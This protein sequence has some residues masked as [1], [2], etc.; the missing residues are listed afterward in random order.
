M[1]AKMKER[2]P[3]NW[4][5]NYK[6]YKSATKFVIPYGKKDLKIFVTIASDY[7]NLGDIAITQTQIAYLQTV[8]PS[9]NIISVYASET[10]SAMKEMKKVQRKR[11]YY[12]YRRGKYGGLIQVVR[13]V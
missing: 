13:R 5:I 12:H 2:I 7:G 11:Y 4:K 1:I 8:Y 10:Y 9:Y 3:L 6:Y